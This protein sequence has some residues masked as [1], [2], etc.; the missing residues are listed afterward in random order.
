MIMTALCLSCGKEEFTSETHNPDPNPDSGVYMVTVAAGY[1]EAQS[2]E[3]STRTTFNFSDGVY[4]WDPGDQ[5]GLFATLYGMTSPVLSN[6]LMNG[7]HTQQVANTTFTGTLTAA[8]VGALSSTNRYD[9]YS[10]FPYNG[11]IGTFPNI[12]FSIPSSLNVTP[13]TFKPTN[14]DIPMVAEPKI[15]QPSIIYLDGSGMDPD[16]MIHLDYKHVMSYA[17]IEMDCNLTSQQITTIRITNQN[18]AQLWGNYNYNMLTG[19]G[20][21]SGGSSVLTI[22]I[23]GGLTVGG[24][25]ILYIPMP[26]VN[27]SGHTMLFEFNPGSASGNAYVNKT[28]YG[29]N[30]QKGHIHRLRVAPAATYTSSVSFTTTVAGY[31]HIEAWG[32]NGGSGRGGKAGGVSQKVTGLYQL[33]AGSTIYVYVG[34]AGANTS[35][36]GGGTEPAG[37]SNGSSYGNGGNGGNGGTGGGGAGGKGGAGG[38][39]TLVFMNGASF[40]SNL[41]L[42][43]GGAGGGGGSASALFGSYEPGGGGNGGVANSLGTNGGDA[44]GNEGGYGGLANGIGND[45]GSGGNG[46][47]NADANGNGGIGGAGQGGTLLYTSGAG[48]GGGGGG[49]TTGGG[50]AEGGGRSTGINVAG[51][52]GGGAGG[53]SY[54]TGTVANPGLSLP[55][56]GRPSVNGYAVITFFRP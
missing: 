28:I 12:S 20:S 38:A 19:S 46:G 1:G 34:T 7:T 51:G 9:Y 23:P 16:Q 4:Y 21:Y 17:A 32:G 52:G 3:P 2:E 14:M 6:I 11:S 40:P 24:G 50:G 54:L 15:D 22:N 10:Y 27:M 30:F 45:G 55:N 13:N 18:G 26:V 8:H 47:G 41:R 25:D 49:Y 31:Y 56:N 53:A 48:G 44:G 33:P 37:G 35:D 39:G 42:V 5:V 36:T 43:S 29:A